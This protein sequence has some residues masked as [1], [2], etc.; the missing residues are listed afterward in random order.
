MASRV[1]TERL[2]L[3]RMPLTM[4]SHATYYLALQRGASSACHPMPA[5][6]AAT[7]RAMLFYR[8]VIRSPVIRALAMP[9]PP[10]PL[11]PPQT[12]PPDHA[13]TNLLHAWREGS[14]TAFASL[15]DQVY[16]RLHS[17]SALRVAQ[18]GKST[19][20]PTELLHEVLADVMKTPMDWQNR[21][22][23]FAT[24]SLAMRAML[25]D[26]ARARS[27]NKRGGD[28]LQ[29]TFTDMDGASSASYEMLLLDQVLTKLEAE[30][31]RSG[32]V[33]HLTYFAGLS[34]EEIA[35]VL[36]ISIPTVT[37][38]LRFA[39]A[40]VQAAFDDER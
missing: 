19:L 36:S 15:I 32:Q 5:N 37:R 27:R 13:L 38:D 20:S 35:N 33:L 39:K 26:H 4:A 29:V 14:G 31:P 28:L 24:M 1:Q 21:A 40:R 18:A 2:R 17:M 10:P 11:L 25:V 34:L 7:Y 6:A 12:P 30:D 22:H 23:F 16:A 3:R 8:F 9:P